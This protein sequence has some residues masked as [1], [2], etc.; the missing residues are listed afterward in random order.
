MI[1]ASRADG[2]GHREEARGRRGDPDSGASRFIAWIASHALA[3]TQTELLDLNK[4]A[5][6]QS[7]TNKSFRAMNG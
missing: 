3:M 5:R 4:Q 2:I 6:G 7:C 1:G